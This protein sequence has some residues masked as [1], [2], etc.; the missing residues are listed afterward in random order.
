MTGVGVNLYDESF[1]VLGLERKGM[2]LAIRVDG[3]ELTRRTIES[4]LSATGEWPLY[5]GGRL[6]NFYIGTSEISEVVM[7]RGELAI[8]QRAKLEEYLQRAP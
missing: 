2:T 8:D 6:D 4:T 5:L 3:N 7:H 1:H